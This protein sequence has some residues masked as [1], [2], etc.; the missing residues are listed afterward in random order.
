ARRAP[1]APPAPAAGRDPEGR[2]WRRLAA[3]LV[4]GALLPAVVLAAVHVMGDDAR[5]GHP[6]GGGT[7]SVPPGMRAAG[8]FT[9]LTDASYAPLEF[10]DAHGL[11][12]FDIELG[13]AIADRLGLRVTVVQTTF[14]TLIPKLLAG[15]GDAVLS[16]MTDTRE[17]ERTIDFVDYLKGGTS[18]LTPT[19]AGQPDDLW[20]CG[21]RVAVVEGTTQKDDIGKNGALTRKCRD[22]GE[23]PPKGTASQSVAE[24]LAEISAGRAD[25]ALLDAPMAGYAAGGSGGRFQVAGAPSGVVPLGIGVRKGGGRPVLDALASLV[26]D[27]TYGRVAGKWGLT[28]LTESGPRLNGAVG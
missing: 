13:R 10:T 28:A 9:V 18:L 12:G 5:G 2:R 27:G 25:A 8:T 4:A 17:R 3:P 16:G 14:D 7:I 26:A 11:T 6:Q 21:K 20:V 22:A 24:V 15:Q 1:P 19:G 23:A